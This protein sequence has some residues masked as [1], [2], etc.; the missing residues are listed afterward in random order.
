MATIEENVIGIDLGTS[1]CVCAFF[2]NGKAEIIPNSE[3]LRMTPSFVAYTDKKELIVGQVAK[4]QALN[5][6]HNTFYSVKK[7][8]GR[9]N[10]EVDINKLQLAYNVLAENGLLKLDCPIMEK[11]FAPE[12]ISASILQKLKSDASAYL[13]EEVKKAVITVPAYFNDSQRQATKDAG[14]IA[15]LE[16][17]RIINEP[18][19]AAI[20]FGLDKCDNETILVFDLGGGTFDVSIL[21]V[22]DGVFEVLATSGDTQLGGDNFDEKIGQWLIKRFFEKENIDLSNNPRAIA[23]IKDAAEK[24]KIDLSILQSIRISLPFICN[25]GQKAKH[26]EETLT[27]KDFNKL[28]ENLVNRC[29][30]PISKAINDAD[31]IISDLKENVLVGGSTRIPSIQNM[32]ES[33]L[34]KKPNRSVNPDEVVALG[35]AIQ[36]GVLS[37]KISNVV[38]LDVTPLSLGVEIVGG[39]VEIIIPRNTLVPTKKFKCFSTAVDNQP[40]VD[41]HILQGERE[42]VSDNKS[43]GIVRLN[44]IP[45]APRGI[46]IIEV[47]FEIDS[48]GILSVTAKDKG[49]GQQQSVTVEGTSNLSN[50]EIDQMVRDAELNAKVDLIAKDEIN[51]FDKGNFYLQSGQKCLAKLNPEKQ[52]EFQWIS[53][54]KLIQNLE[55][56]LKEQNLLK[57]ERFIEEY[58]RFFNN[59]NNTD[60]DLDDY[61]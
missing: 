11:T 27:R 35:A 26:L 20:S 37:G 46:P 1:N 8:I 14:K 30:E 61:V 58:E 17:I 59:T 34:G 57:C 45:S 33:F 51:T 29:R 23:R 52:I 18:T 6:P 44:N 13:K 7:L 39:I 19:A 56:C 31:L 3:D 12:Q 40:A 32:V 47:I 10:K 43:L 42:F 28:T 5:N 38:L 24:A 53:F 22:G 36:A 9:S 21:E 16:V 4:R 41:L 49:T 60:L 2:E 50:D 55:N 15:G 25:I 54:S 48:N